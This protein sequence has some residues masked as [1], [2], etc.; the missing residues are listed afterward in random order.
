MKNTLCLIGVYL[1]LGTGCSPTHAPSGDPEITKLQSQVS[2]MNSAKMKQEQE[3]LRI[4]KETT[5]SIQQL[6]KQKELLHQ[7][8]RELEINVAAARSENESSLS[9]SAQENQPDRIA[10]KN[11]HTFTAEVTSVQGDE[12]HIMIGEQEQTGPLSAIEF[13]EFSSEISD[14]QEK[15]SPT[16]PHP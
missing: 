10:L 8:V 12:V 2:E 13:I 1:F 14:S 3:F 6:E 7:Q 5:S 15:F 4:Q 9:V 11:G 16:P